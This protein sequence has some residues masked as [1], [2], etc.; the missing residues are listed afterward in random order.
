MFT[1]N[2]IAGEFNALDEILAD[3]LSAHEIS[4]IPVGERIIVIE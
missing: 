3:Y 2:K 1:D 4:E